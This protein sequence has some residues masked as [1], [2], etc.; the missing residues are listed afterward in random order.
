MVVSLIL[1]ALLLFFLS[2]FEKGEI[3]HGLVVLLTP[4]IIILFAELYRVNRLKEI[5]SNRF[6]DQPPYIWR[7]DTKDKISGNIFNYDIIQLINYLNK[8]NKPILFLVEQFREEDHQA[9]LYIEFSES[10]KDK[11]IAANSFFHSGDWRIYRNEKYPDSIS[12]KDL[13][14]IYSNSSLIICGGFYRA[15]N[16][17]TNEL[18]GWTEH[19]FNWEKRIILT[20]VPLEPNL[21]WEDVLEDEFTILP[22][23][24]KGIQEI[25]MALEQGL[26]YQTDLDSL[27][28]PLPEFERNETQVLKK[29]NNDITLKHLIDWIAAAA[30]L[31]RLN[32]DFTLKIGHLLVELKKIPDLT[33]DEIRIISRLPWFRT[34][35]MPDHIRQQLVSVLDENTKTEARKLMVEMLEENIPPSN[36]HAHNDFRTELVG[37]KLLIPDFSQEGLRNELYELNSIGYEEDIFVKEWIEDQKKVHDRWVPK[38]LERFVYNEGYF[39]FGWSYKLLLLLFF[40]IGFFFMLNFESSVD[41]PEQQSKMEILIKVKDEKEE[42]ISKAKVVFYFLPQDTIET[43]ENGIASIEVDSNNQ[44]KHVNLK[45]FKKGYET[46][47]KKHFISEKEI[48]VTL[49]HKIK[50]NKEKPKEADSTLTSIGKIHCQTCESYDNIKLET[51]KGEKLP[52]NIRKDGKVSMFDNLLDFYESK[53]VVISKPGYFPDTFYFFKDVPL[54]IVLTPRTI[55]F[56]VYENKLPNSFGRVRNAIIEIKKI[57]KITTNERGE[58]WIPLPQELKDNLTIPIIVSKKGYNTVHL[59]PFIKKEIR[60]KLNKINQMPP[61]PPVGTPDITEP[62]VE[63]IEEI[64]EGIIYNC[65]K[66]VGLENVKINWWFSNDLESKNT[67]YSDINGKYSITKKRDEEISIEIDEDTYGLHEFEGRDIIVGINKIR[68]EVL[69]KNEPVVNASVEFDGETLYTNHEGNIFTTTCFNKNDEVNIKIKIKGH[70]G[71][72]SNDSRFMDIIIDSSDKNKQRLFI[73]YDR[74]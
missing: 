61:D 14:N 52:T 63:V 51:L 40:P 70:S 29:L 39:L 4:F 65:E 16:L 67:I 24:Q 21:I 56:V 6:I 68:I 45:V 36:S 69:R 47:N 3:W 74:H 19:F 42:A 62:P 38:W 58:K 9:K 28:L 66:T 18:H 54:N 44:K 22:F 1:L 71:F 41:D 8:Q 60:I 20:P 2:L 64:V 30:L 27:G 46:Y 11:N 13:S 59:N 5:K 25:P 55:T 49:K 34:G 26:S 57:K 43:D 50:K 23:N 10:L 15:I 33:Y 48:I 72:V 17:N 7:L 31:S 12:L 53:I 32:W 73:G 37:L 35:R